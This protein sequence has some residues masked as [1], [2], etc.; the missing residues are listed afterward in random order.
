[1]TRK[2]ITML[3]G[4]LLLMNAV[5]VASVNEKYGFMAF[6]LLMVFIVTNLKAVKEIN[7]AK[8]TPVE[9]ISNSAI[10]KGVAYI[11]LT[12]VILSVFYA[13]ITGID[14]GKYINST[15]EVLL[16]AIFPMI[17]AIVISQIKVFIEYGKKS[18]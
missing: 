16:L 13:L 2:Q 3:V 15:G 12:V 18:N 17:P 1:M 11:Y 9:V 14:L 4:W 8:P 6:F 10:L 7:F 5:I